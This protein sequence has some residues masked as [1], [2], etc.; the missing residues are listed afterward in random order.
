MKKFLL[1]LSAL[2]V[3]VSFATAQ[4]YEI[5]TSTGTLTGGTNP[6]YEWVSNQ[7]DLTLRATNEGGDAKN[8]SYI[9]NG[10][11][12]SLN[13]YNSKGTYYTTTY[14][15]SVPEDGGYKITGYNIS[16]TAYK[17]VIVNGIEYTDGNSVTVTK[18]NIDGYS[19]TFTVERISD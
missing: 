8:I 2:F 12:L 11:K 3:G 17:T 10:T 15:I 19:A 18:N 7:T 5:S 14:T 9:S 4:T 1:F 16:A 13:A 6:S